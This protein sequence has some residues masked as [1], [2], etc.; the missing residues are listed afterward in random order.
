MHLSSHS[1]DLLLRWP[2]EICPN[3]V[4]EGVSFESSFHTEMDISFSL[5]EKSDLTS[6]IMYL[7][8]EKYEKNTSPV[9]A[10]R[11]KKK[12]RKGNVSNDKGIF[13]EH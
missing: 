1:F 5:K 10:K 8:H 12:K 3:D 11:E 13:E 6:R 9:G 2:Q 4:Q 7:V